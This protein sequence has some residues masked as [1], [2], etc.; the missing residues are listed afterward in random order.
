MYRLYEIQCDLIFQFHENKLGTYESLMKNY[1]FNQ[2][3][4]QFLIREKRFNRRKKKI[5]VSLF[6]T[7]VSILEYRLSCTHIVVPQTPFPDDHCCVRS[8]VLHS[9][10][11]MTIGSSCM[12]V[13][14]VIILTRY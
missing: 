11:L 5:T 12:T 10:T 1:I 3:G 8:L 6:L 14:V 9:R 7:K 13:T 4:L 2:N